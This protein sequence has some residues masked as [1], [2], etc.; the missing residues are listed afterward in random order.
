M[1]LNNLLKLLQNLAKIA[2]P[3]RARIIL[4]AVSNPKI[5]Q[6]PKTVLDSLKRVE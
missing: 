6:S 5:C 4:E 1:I 3:N 2:I